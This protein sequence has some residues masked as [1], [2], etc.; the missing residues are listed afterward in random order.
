MLNAHSP[1]A[2]VDRIQ[3]A[4][5]QAIASLATASG[6]DARTLAAPLLG[7]GSRTAIEQHL[8]DDIKRRSGAEQLAA[9]R[10]LGAIGTDSSL[11]TLLYLYAV[12]HTRAAA[13]ASVAELLAPNQLAA[14]I[15]GEPDPERQRHLLGVLV[16]HPAP[17]GLS[18]YLSFVANPVTSDA[19][20][21]ALDDV[22]DAPVD[23]LFT[24]LDAPRTD[25][26]LAAARALGRINGPIVS[27]RLAT[28][29]ARNVHRRE[30][31]AALMSSG[32]SEASRFLSG[33]R[34]IPSLLSVIRSVE[35]QLRN[36]F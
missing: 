25:Y 29:V 7:S 28:M 3:P 6:A 30:A 20:L 24:H 36:P 35:L 33:F 14:R 27:E 12:E 17:R 18:T 26:R 21:A 31:L 8:L 15:V 11:P 16:S 10:L 5:D 19:A 34:Q 22:A 23:A 4:I 1:T 13:A 9:I 2:S 32:G